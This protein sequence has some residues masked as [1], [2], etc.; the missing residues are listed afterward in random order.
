MNLFELKTLAMSDEAVSA[1]SEIASCTLMDFLT[2]TYSE[3]KE[4]DLLP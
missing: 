3:S 1:G 2:H 4:S